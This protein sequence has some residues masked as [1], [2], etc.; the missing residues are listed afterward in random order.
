MR[1]RKVQPATSLYCKKKKKTQIRKKSNVT[2]KV[3]FCQY[4]LENVHPQLNSTSST[5]FCYYK[6]KNFNLFCFVTATITVLFKICKMMLQKITIFPQSLSS[7]INKLFTKHNFAFIWKVLSG[8]NHKK[9]RPQ[10]NTS[11]R[12][13]SVS[14]WQLSL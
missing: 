7:N 9:C 3:I 13:D 8:T 5:K 1:L 11:S 2:K 4:P 10:R 12:T 14:Y 6:C